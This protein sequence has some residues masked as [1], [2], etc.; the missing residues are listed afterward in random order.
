MLR[1]RCVP[2][3]RTLT[4]LNILALVPALAWRQGLTREECMICEAML[5]NAATI[6]DTKERGVTERDL[7]DLALQH[8]GA[9]FLSGIDHVFSKRLSLS[10]IADAMQVECYNVASR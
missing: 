3:P 2:M 6:A 5:R 10:S 7:L 8:N 9:A 1:T 4:N